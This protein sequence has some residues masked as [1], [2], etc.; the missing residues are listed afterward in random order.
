MIFIKLDGGTYLKENKD[1]FTIDNLDFIILNFNIIQD[2][3][4]LFV[5][6]VI[7]EGDNIKL[8][9][10][11]LL[12][13]SIP[14]SDVIVTRVLSTIPLNKEVSGLLLNE[15]RYEYIVSFKQFNNR[16]NKNRLNHIYLIDRNPIDYKYTKK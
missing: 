5:D 15:L 8:L 1:T 16:Y 4:K 13:S 7:I 9:R 14:V 6:S 10:G 11:N 12:V 3:I 2:E